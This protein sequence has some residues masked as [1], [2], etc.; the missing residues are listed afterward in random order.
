MNVEKMANRRITLTDHA[1]DRI[2]DP[3]L[4]DGTMDPK[5]IDVQQL[6]EETGFLTYVNSG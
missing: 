3:P 6:Y 5:A 4:L 2:F 1:T